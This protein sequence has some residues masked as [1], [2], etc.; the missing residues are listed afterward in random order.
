M[1]TNVFSMTS[2]KLG[3]DGAVK[4]VIFPAYEPFLIASVISD[5]LFGSLILFVNVN[6]DGTNSMDVAM[7]AGACYG[8]QHFVLEGVAFCLYQNGCGYESAYKASKW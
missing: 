4:H 3:M 2:L 1:A 8:A 5:V 6:L 7:L